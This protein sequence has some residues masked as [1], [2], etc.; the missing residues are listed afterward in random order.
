MLDLNKLKTDPQKVNEGTWVPY[1]QKSRLLIA[2]HNNRQAENFRLMETLK[3]ND[4]FSRLQ[5]EDVTEE[6]IKR[7]E[8]IS[9]EIE[10]K[11]LAYHILKGWEGIGRGKEPLEYTPELGYD[12]LSDPENFDFREDVKHFSMSN[13]FRPEDS[14][15]KTVKKPAAS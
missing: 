13:S 11:A 9:L 12:L 6:E 14:A 2:K 5:D 1:R 4:I 7:A 8:K 10:T 3:H 15:K